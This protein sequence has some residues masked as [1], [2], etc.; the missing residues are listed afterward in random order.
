MTG[1]QT[2]ALPI[3]SF[4]LTTVLLGGLTLGAFGAGA[5]DDFRRNMDEH[6]TTVSPNMVGLTGLLAYQDNPPLVTL[7]ELR[8]IRERRERIYRAQLM[9]LFA[10]AV[11]ACAAASPFLDDVA[12]AALGAPLIFVGLNLAS[13]YYAFLVVLV[14]AHRGHPRRL[15]LVFTAE[16]VSHA[17]L[18]FEEREALLYLYRS[19]ILLYLFLALPLEQWREPPGRGKMEA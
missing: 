17:L 19:L 15:A 16:A 9:T 2:C 18:L 8:E 3:S 6:R 4:G 11:L 13:Y 10:L 1:V 14:L 5:W 7:E 12:A